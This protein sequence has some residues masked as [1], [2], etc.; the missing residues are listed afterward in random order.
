[1]NRVRASAFTLIEILVALAIMVIIVGCTYGIYFAATRSAAR[2]R[3]RAEVERDARVLLRMMGREIRCSYFPVP[4]ETPT[5]QS[6]PA[7]T[8]AGPANPISPVNPLSANPLSAPSALSPAPT[9]ENTPDATMTAR[10][11]RPVYDYLAGPAGR[12]GS[13]LQTLTTGGIADPDQPSSGLYNIA[14]RLDAGAKMIWRRQ[15]DML[16]PPDSKAQDPNWVCVA[17]GVEAV[18]CSFFDGKTWADN[19]KTD[20][21]TGLPYAVKIEIALADSEGR[22]SQYATSI[23]LPLAAGPVAQSTVTA[24][25][26]RE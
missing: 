2:Y 22:V 25:Q 23:N 6:S 16:E 3:A 24:P 12:D 15:V 5:T 4:T 13:F 20:L 7:G 8:A 17:R 21:T 11:D 19:W 14:Y 1:L 18:K 10:K 9:R 26:G